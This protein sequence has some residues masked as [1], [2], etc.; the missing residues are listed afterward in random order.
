VV[1]PKGTPYKDM[2]MDLINYSLSLEAQT[3][4]ANSGVYAPALS[5]AAATAPEE[6]RKTYASAPENMEHMLVLNEQQAAMYMK[7]YTTRWQE[8][9][10][11]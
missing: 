8:F 10:L 4:V 3:V 7:K 6:V 1:V 9:Q 2:V 11:G 5:A